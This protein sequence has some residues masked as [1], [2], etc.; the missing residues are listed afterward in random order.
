M[1]CKRILAALLAGAALVTMAFSL[2]ACGKPASSPSASSTPKDY[3]QILHDAR[4][5]EDNEYEMIFSKG[6]DGKFTARYGYSESYEA[7]QL[8]DE[9]ENMLW[10]L[11]GLEDDMVE[12]FAASVSGMMVQSYAIAIVKPAPGKTDAVVDALKAYVL[13]EQQSMEHY[14]ED[15]YLVAK[16][17]TVT[18]APTGEVI[19]VCCEGSD[20][21]LANIKAALAK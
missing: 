5:E 14:L 19:L 1:K 21:V 13:S 10:P 18:V 2:T 17:A 8:N 7:G 6:D 11:L 16:A 12:D 9:I 20:T 3:T 15:Q 4:P